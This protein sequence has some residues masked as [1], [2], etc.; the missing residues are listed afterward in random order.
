MMPPILMK[1]SASSPDIREIRVE[2]LFHSP[3]TEEASSQLLMQCNHHRLRKFN[4]DSPISP[5]ALGHIIQLPSLEKL[6]LVF[7]SVQLPNPLPPV[8]FPSLQLLDVEYTGAHTW[9]ELLRAIENPV[10]KEISVECPGPDVE[11]FM[12]AFQLTIAQCQMQE[13][14]QEFSVRSPQEFKISP[15]IIACTFS[16]KNL[17][18]L[19]ILSDCEPGI[20]Q[21]FDITDRHI[22]L[23]TKAMPRLESLTIGGAPCNLHSQITF[24]S[25][26]TISHRC[27]RLSTL[28]IH[29]NAALFVS[30]VETGPGSAGATLC[31]SDLKT[32]SPELCLVTTIDVGSIPLPNS[33]TSTIVALGLLGVFPHLKEIEYEEEDWAD[34]QDLIGVCHR[35]G[36][37]AFGKG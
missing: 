29:F 19:E 27:P 15:G 21:T 12:E 3:A 14:L 25:L 1:L 5:A 26:Y 30:G 10:L 16:F 22:E 28:Q 4:V 18:S 24:K 6:W 17:T 36:R 11:Q 20:C 7:N 13:I 2:L 37:F 35:M 34:V 9:L 23:L 33:D 31:L 32:P 8:V